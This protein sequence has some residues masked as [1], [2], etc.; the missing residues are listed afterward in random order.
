MRMIKDDRKKILED[1]NGM[2]M[3]FFKDKKKYYGSNIKKIDS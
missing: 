3:I 2:F 1:I